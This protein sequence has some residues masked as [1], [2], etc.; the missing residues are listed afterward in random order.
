[1]TLDSIRE[2]PLFHESQT[3]SLS[4]DSGSSSFIAGDFL[5]PVHRERRRRLW[6]QDWVIR[7]AGS[8]SESGKEWDEMAHAGIKIVDSEASC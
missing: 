7:D 3:L 8:V 2:P 4:A 1:M 5:C 6:V